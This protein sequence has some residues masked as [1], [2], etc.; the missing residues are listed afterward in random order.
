MMLHAAQQLSN[1]LLFNTNFAV[2][3]LLYCFSG[4]NFRK[5]LKNALIRTS[6]KNPLGRMSK[7]L[8]S[9]SMKQRKSSSEVGSTVEVTVV[10]ET[11]L[12]ECNEEFEQENFNDP[13]EFR[14]FDNKH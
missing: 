13:K 8:S 6:Q 2:N 14:W 11:K 7:N 12:S 1:I 5:S 10:H 9:M 3:F 4:K